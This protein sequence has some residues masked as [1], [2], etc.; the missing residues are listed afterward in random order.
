MNRV[1]SWKTSPTIVA[2]VSIKDQGR[3][4]I[5]SVIS[6]VSILRQIPFPVIYVAI[7][8]KLGEG[9][10]D[11]SECIINNNDINY[12]IKPVVWTGMQS[13]GAA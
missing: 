10:K 8:A 5:L 1:S 11:T 12:N 3:S 13:L 2:C 4:K 7:H 9:I 6:R